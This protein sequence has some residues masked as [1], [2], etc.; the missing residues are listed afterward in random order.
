[1]HPVLADRVYGSRRGR[2]LP[3]SG[4]A[5]E[6]GRQALHAA[7]ISLVHPRTGK[8]L[9]VVAPLAPDLENLLDRLRR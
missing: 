2:A 5:R 3:R 8:R 7:E 9:R 4:P 1:G 6:F